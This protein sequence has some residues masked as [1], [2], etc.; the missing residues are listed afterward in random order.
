MGS[1]F[2]ALVSKPWNNENHNRGFSMSMMAMLLAAQAVTASE[3]RSDAFYVAGVRQGMSMAEYNALIAN[4]RYESKP[5]ERDRFLASIDGQAIVV[6]FCQNRIASALVSYNSVQWL[7]SIMAFQ[8]AGLAFNGF[9]AYVEEGQDQ[10]GSLVTGVT[11]PKG[12]NYFVTPMV[13]AFVAAGRDFPTF[14]LN[15]EM[16]N[17]PCRP[18]PKM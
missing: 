2:V 9:A 10:S 3:I 17:N 12:Y 8:K 18:I 1:A 7:Q 15:F 11:I 13:K 16:T 14:Q 4:G 6:T 5:L